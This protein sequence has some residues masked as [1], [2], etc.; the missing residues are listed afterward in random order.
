M[1]DVRGVI[2]AASVELFLR[3]GGAYSTTIF[4]F[5]EAKSAD[6]R[7][8]VCPKNVAFEIKYPNVDIEG[9]VI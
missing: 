9:S 4:N 2:D 7:Y 1:N 8:L 5:D 6:G 3:S